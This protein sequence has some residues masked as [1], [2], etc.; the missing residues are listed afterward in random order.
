MIAI[1][2]DTNSF[3]TE[4]NAIWDHLLPA[5]GAEALSADA[6]AQEKLKQAVANLV[7]H[8]APAKK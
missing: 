5:F 1:T 2:A 7:A 4:M 8:L 3:Q 6:A